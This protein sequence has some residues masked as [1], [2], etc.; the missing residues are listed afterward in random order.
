MMMAIDQPRQDDETTG[1]E[2]HI[3]RCGGLLPFGEGFENNAI[4]DKQPVDSGA[5][6]G[7]D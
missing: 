5:C 4:F 6:T 1:I 2:F 7:P 3:E